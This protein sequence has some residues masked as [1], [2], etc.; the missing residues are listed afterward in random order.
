MESLLFVSVGDFVVPGD[1]LARISSSGGT[2]KD[3]EAEDVGG[4]S[5]TLHAS[6]GTYAR[7]NKIIY[8]SACGKVVVDKQKDDSWVSFFYTKSHHI[9]VHTFTFVLCVECECGNWKSPV[10]DSSSGKCY[11]WQGG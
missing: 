8:A 10:V 5:I 9:H 4:A 6:D 7:H 2:S 3:S 1:R 11:S